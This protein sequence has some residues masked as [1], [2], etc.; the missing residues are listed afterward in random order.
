GF[1]L[2]FGIFLFLFG[3]SA[4]LTE[5]STDDDHH[6]HHVDLPKENAFI[7]AIYMRF[8]HD[9]VKI[10]EHGF[11]EILK[12]LKIGKISEDEHE[13]H[14]HNEEEHEGHAHDSHDDE[15]LR[16]SSGGLTTRDNIKSDFADSH[17][18]EHVHEDKRNVTT[19]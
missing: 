15:H 19:N 10:D 11:E 5:F 8:G 4:E 3:V 7:D 9:G 14:G 17:D 12:Q 6:H 18:E 16:R 13:G 2:L 1:I